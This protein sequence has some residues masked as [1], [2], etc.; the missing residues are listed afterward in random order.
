VTGLKGWRTGL[1]TSGLVLLALVALACSSQS[2]FPDPLPATDGA[3]V[4]D[5]GGQPTSSHPTQADL[6]GRPA[7]VLKGAPAGE[8][9]Q[10]TRIPALTDNPTAAPT[11]TSEFEIGVP[12]SDTLP[13]EQIKARTGTP[14]STVIQIYELLEKSLRTGDGKLW[15]ELRSQT[16][17]DEMTEDRK[18]SLE[19]DLPPQPNVHLHLSSVVVQTDAAAVFG[20]F[21]GEGG[22]SQFHAVQ[23]VLENG[24]WKIL[25]ETLAEGPIHQA[26]FL[27][28]QGGAFTREGFPWSDVPYAEVVPGIGE[29]WATQAV[30]D[31]SFL[32]LRF[33]GDLDLPSVGEEVAD[34]IVP[35]LPLMPLAEIEVVPSQSG[36]RPGNRFTV[37]IADVTTQRPIFDETGKALSTRYF[38]N[39]SLA[40]QDEEGEVIFYDFADSLDRLI[41]VDGRS[42]EVKIPGD[43]LGP[44]N[45]DVA[46]VILHDRMG[47]FLPYE[48]S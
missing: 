24:T 47:R 5:S 25:K 17:L 8:A 9:A 1:A 12:S 10:S 20:K 13:Y 15:L 14:E 44:D 32:Y 4:A 2:Q 3:G 22:D 42:I 43:S 33:E 19:E 7:L 27:P 38:M 40:L 26:S 6:P 28:P 31:E 36:G 48:V 45:A 34:Q 41:A 35:S 11:P 37:T 16:V 46:R 18:R 39:Y 30:Y 21:V 29:T 23:F